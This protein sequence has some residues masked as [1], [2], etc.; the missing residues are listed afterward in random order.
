MGDNLSGIIIENP[1]QI[2]GQIIYFKN[3]LTLD[4]NAILFKSFSSISTEL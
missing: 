1:E 3:A 2:Y 4:V